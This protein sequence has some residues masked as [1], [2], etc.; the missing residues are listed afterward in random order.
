MQV[1]VTGSD[2]MLKEHIKG[3]Y[4]ARNFQVYNPNLLLL[5]ETGLN[6]Q[7]REWNEVLTDRRTDTHLHK[8][9]YTQQFLKVQAFKYPSTKK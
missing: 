3:N 7:D 4:Y 8:G 5:E 6:G 1:K 2:C 9:H